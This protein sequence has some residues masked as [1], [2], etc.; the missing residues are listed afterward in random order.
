MTVKGTQSSG[1]VNQ[2]NTLLNLQL[3]ETDVLAK[4]SLYTSRKSHKFMT[5]DSLK[6]KMA[7]VWKSTNSLEIMEKTQNSSKINN[8]I[9]K[10]PSELRS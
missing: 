6:M 7:K 1:H 2:M 8:K 10:R 5:I 4:K 3:W 9:K